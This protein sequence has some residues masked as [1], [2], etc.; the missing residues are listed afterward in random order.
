MKPY[1]YVTRKLP[2][3][4]IQTLETFANVGMW[5]SEEEPVPRRILIKEAEK[6]DALLTMLSD[7]I[8]AEIFQVSKQLKVVANLAVGFDNIDIEQATKQG[9]TICNTPDVL[10]DTT[11]DLAFSLMLMV[12]R[13]L[14]ESAELVKNGE[15]KS[16]S[17]LFMAGTDVHHKTLGIV[18]MGSIGEALAKRAMGFDMRILYHNRHRKIEIEHKLGVEYR[19]FDELVTESDYVVCLTPLTEE[20]KGMFTKAVFQ[21][22][23]K[24]AF[25]INVARGAIVVEEDL[26]QALREGEIAGA[27]L[28]VF[29]TE[30]IDSNHPLLQLKNVVALPHIGSASIETRT[31]MMELCCENIEAVLNNRKPIAV[32]NE[33]LKSR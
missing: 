21:R 30:P 7:K 19:T 20:T 23:K 2:E 3:N 5:E 8:D 17:P 1:V 22:M 18:G 29:Q 12:G 26:L 9:I 11:A 28:D 4:I 13:R 14:F 10:T 31:A 32:V 27:G 24:S 6:A 25:F 15:W 33:E 16:W